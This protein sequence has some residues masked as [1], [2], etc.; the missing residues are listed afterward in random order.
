MPSY[1]TIYLKFSLDNTKITIYTY[2]TE[3]QNLEPH[4]NTENR[5]PRSKQFTKEELLSAIEKFDN[6]KIKMAEFLKIGNWALREQL[7]KYG[8]NVDKRIDECKSRTIVNPN[9]RST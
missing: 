5:K 7:K 4:M 8:I 3:K 2:H 9:K 1:T 6:D